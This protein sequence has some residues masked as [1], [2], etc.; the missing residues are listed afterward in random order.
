MGGRPRRA[1]AKS[2]SSRENISVRASVSQQ[3]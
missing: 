1:E 3:N 2:M